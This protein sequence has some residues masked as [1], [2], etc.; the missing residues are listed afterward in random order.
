MA[1]ATATET[2]YTVVLP[3]PMM[4]EACSQLPW[5]GALL[6]TAANI[7]SCSQVSASRDF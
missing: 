1:L 6:H 7:V 5:P 2:S 3:P 4:P